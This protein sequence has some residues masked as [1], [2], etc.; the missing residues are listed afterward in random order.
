MAAERT[1]RATEPQPAQAGPRRGHGSGPQ[2]APGGP[3]GWLP[4]AAGNRAVAHLLAATGPTPVVARQEADAQEI[5][6]LSVENAALLSLLCHDR[7]EDI[8]PIF[9]RYV[10]DDRYGQDLHDAYWGFS[11]LGRQTAVQ[12]GRNRRSTPEELERLE[13]LS[14]LWSGVRE[15][16]TADNAATARR[17]LARAQAQALA[18]Q[19]QLVF[20]YRQAILAGQGPEEIDLTGS[21]KSLKFVAE[22]VVSL[23]SAINTAQA[24]DVGRDVAPLVQVLDKTLTVVNVFSDWQQT[25]PSATTDCTAPTP[26]SAV[27]P[28]TPTSWGSSGRGAPGGCRDP[29]RPWWSSSTSG[30]TCSTRSN[31]T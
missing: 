14:G 25:G 8:A 7:V 30:A 15:R 13:H 1:H 31:V 6:V 28:C 23:L 18:L 22:Q 24:A 20:A 10:E 2:R 26:R 27:S 29:R 9:R 16:I 17:T 4:Q 21:D 3:A 19:V 12:D 11:A 5:P